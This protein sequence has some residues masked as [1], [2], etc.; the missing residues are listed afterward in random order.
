MDA[1]A[2]LCG[3]VIDDAGARPLMRHV[4]NVAGDLR[5]FDAAAADLLAP[6][7]IR[8][9]EGVRTKAGEVTALS[10][11]RVFQSATD[12][13]V[14]L[15]VGGEKRAERAELQY[16]AETVHW[17]RLLCVGSLRSFVP[18]CTMQSEQSHSTPS[19][20]SR[21]VHGRLSEPRS[22]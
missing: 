20:I 22:G 12:S 5:R 13:R 15:L 6:R 18:A 10:C 8:A 16:F 17:E 4:N 21:Y 19:R 11:G 1:H 9:S 7:N 14:P 2:Y 3:G